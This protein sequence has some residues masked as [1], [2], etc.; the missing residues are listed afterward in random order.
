MEGCRGVVRTGNIKGRRKAT[1]ALQNIVGM[2]RGHR[3]F[4]SWSG[5]GKGFE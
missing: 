4:E 5:G 1:Y 2:R 3:A